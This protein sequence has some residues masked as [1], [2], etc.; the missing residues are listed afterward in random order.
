[1][2]LSYSNCG[3]LN[4]MNLFSVYSDT[5][6]YPDKKFIGVCEEAIRQEPQGFR[7]PGKWIKTQCE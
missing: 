5:P 7:F 4:P 3:L 1:M 6:Y 2:L